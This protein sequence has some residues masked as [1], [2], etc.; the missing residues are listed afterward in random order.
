VRDQPHALGE[1]PP[2]HVRHRRRPGR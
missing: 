2:P 1:Q